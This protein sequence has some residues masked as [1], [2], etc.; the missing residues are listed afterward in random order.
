LVLDPTAE[1]IAEMTLL[2]ADQVRAFGIVPKAALLSHSSFGASHAP[3]AK[4]MRVALELIRKAA[5]DLEVDGE[6]HADAALVPAIRDKAVPDSRLTETANLLVMP[7][8]DAAN[9][10]LNLL[11]AASDGLLVGPLLLGM[12]KPIHVLVPSVTARGIANVTA[13]AVAQAGR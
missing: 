2:A 4:K 12:R 13:L 11:K 5:P 8:L 9:I 3:S 1:Q 10:S 6:M 7:G